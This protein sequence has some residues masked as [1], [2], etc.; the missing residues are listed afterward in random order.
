MRVLASAEQV[1]KERAGNGAGREG[2]S[3]DH[4][5][6]PPGRPA[7]GV[8]RR[9]L[10]LSRRRRAPVGSSRPSACHGCAVACIGQPPPPSAPW[11]G[12]MGWVAGPACGPR[13]RWRGASWLQL[14]GV[15][16]GLASRGCAGG[17]SFCP[18]FVGGCDC[19]WPGA[20][21]VVSMSKTAAAQRILPA[22]V[23]L[24]W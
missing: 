21:R 24:Y 8:P 22:L 7:G 16:P 4:P 15:R 11:A 1:R 10:G 18:L 13:L 20:G 2:G 6:L 14:A 12:A 5:R 17:Y 19:F 9:P 23:H 3:G